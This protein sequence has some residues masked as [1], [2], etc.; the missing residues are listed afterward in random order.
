MQADR[1]D[2]RAIFTVCLYTYWMRCGYTLLEAMC[3]SPIL[4]LFNTDAY[5]LASNTHANFVY[6]NTGNI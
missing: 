5:W 4:E 1:V 2:Y 3:R 6:L